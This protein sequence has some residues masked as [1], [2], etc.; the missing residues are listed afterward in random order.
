MGP[1]KTDEGNEG[2]IG[3]NEM[4]KKYISLALEGFQ[5]NIPANLEVCCLIL[6]GNEKNLGRLGRRRR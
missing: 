4:K 5:G 3:W 1:R 6:G 2:K